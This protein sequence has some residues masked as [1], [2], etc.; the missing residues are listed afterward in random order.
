MPLFS[1]TACLV[2]FVNPEIAAD[3][4]ISCISQP[5]NRSS[6]FTIFPVEIIVGNQK[7]TLKSKKV[8][9]R[10][11]INVLPR[12]SKSIAIEEKR[13]MRKIVSC[14]FYNF[15]LNIILAITLKIFF[16]K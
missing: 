1:G 11:E 7:T 10:S 13:M 15:T 4:I 5:E 8:P 14:I 3:H 6:T 2:S 16:V 9:T 12:C